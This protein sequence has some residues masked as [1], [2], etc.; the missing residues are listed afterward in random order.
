MQ[1]SSDVVCGLVHDSNAHTARG[2]QAGSVLQRMILARA[3]AICIK[4]LYQFMCQ[5]K[6]ITRGRC[7]CLTFWEI[8]GL[9]G[10]LCVRR[11]GEPHNNRQMNP[12]PGLEAQG[13]RAQRPR[14]LGSHSLSCSP[15]S[16][17]TKQNE[18]ILGYQKIS[19]LSQE[20]TILSERASLP[21]QVHIQ[22][23]L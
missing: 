15:Y 11:D 3:T 21:W 1:E 22:R 4:I 5:F 20:P 18:G 17:T 14:R 19:T 10:Y 12:M 13:S 16:G 6:R 9:D 23:I 8:D 7:A 2:A